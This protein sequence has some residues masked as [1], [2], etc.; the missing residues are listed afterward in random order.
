M[1]TDIISSLSNF[2]FYCMACLFKKEKANGKEVEK[3]RREWRQAVT[4]LLEPGVEWNGMRWGSGKRTC[5]SSYM[6]CLVGCG[7]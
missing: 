5:L 3:K 2:Y 6:W 7:W 1:E 4:R